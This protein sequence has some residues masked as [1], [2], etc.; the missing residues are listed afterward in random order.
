MTQHQIKRG[1]SLYSFQE[2]Y[3]LLKL[4]LEQCIAKAAE[5]G[6]NGIEIIGE[7]MVPGFPKLTDAFADQ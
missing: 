6:A 3:F 5:I 1:V 7:Q 2:E 4:T